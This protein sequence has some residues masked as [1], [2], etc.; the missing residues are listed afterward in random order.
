VSSRRD[1]I[2]VAKK[3]TKKK[4]LG[5]RKKQKNQGVG[6]RIAK[7]GAEIL[8]CE[9][10]ARPARSESGRS[11]SSGGGREGSLKDP[12]FGKSKK[13]ILCWSEDRGTRHV[14]RRDDGEKNGTGGKEELPPIPEEETVCASRRN[15]LGKPRA[16]MTER[17]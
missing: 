7:Q 6:D 11:N 17:K 9:G 4:T 13:Q 3:C 14:I 10:G 16:T 2:A 8:S 1:A 15:F 12:R 5:V